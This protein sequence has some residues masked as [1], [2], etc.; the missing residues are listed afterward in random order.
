METT[1]G[2]GLAARGAKGAFARTFE[3]AGRLD[4][5]V[6]ASSLLLVAF[7]LVVVYSAS[8]TIAEASLP[9]QTLGALIG[10]VAAALMCR[11]DYRGLAASA[12]PL[13]VVD[14]ALMVAPLVP[15]LS[16][17]ANG[18]VGWVKI[19]L[20]G[21]TF[22]TSELAKPVT[23][24]LMAALAARY[25]GRIERLGDYLK[26]LAVLAV[27]FALIM[28]QP[29]LGTGLVV[30]VGGAAVVVVAGPRRSWVLATLGVLVALVAAVLLTDSIVDAT[31]GDDNS[32]IKDYQMNRLLVFLDPEH[33][34]SS[35]GYNLQQAMIAVGSGGLFGKGLG[36]ATQAGSG[37][38]PEAHTDFVFALLCEE[39]GFVG[40]AFVLVLYLWLIFASLKVALRCDALFGRLAVAG[41][42]AMWTFQ[43]FENVGMCLSLMPITGIPLPFVSFGS[44]SMIVQL[45][46]VGIVQSVAVRCPGRAHGRA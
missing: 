2:A 44:S 23:V 33:D 39:F 11:F 18:I 22:Q 32:L 19:P 27:P 42:V 3:L 14:C 41:I 35:S 36:N 21:L 34:T 12:P 9:R 43:I 29:D 17:E 8:L 7:G 26:L 20:V 30:L 6:L 46:M 5:S 28:L 45:L 24:L 13:F 1:K 40:A 16:Y 4:R 31:L 25:N 15:G 38:L 37:F 10:L